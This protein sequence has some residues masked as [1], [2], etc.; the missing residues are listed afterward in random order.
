MK[1]FTRAYRYR[2]SLCLA[3]WLNDDKKYFHGFQIRTTHNSVDHF[4]W[5]RYF[6]FT[7]QILSPHVWH[8]TLTYHIRYNFILVWITQYG[9]GTLQYR[10]S[11]E[12]RCRKCAN[13]VL[14]FFMF[15]SRSVLFFY[16]GVFFYFFFRMSV[17]EQREHK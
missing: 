8:L 14:S 1:I 6:Y 15:L 4:F 13:R 9:T 12:W 3:E 10:Y 17:Y 16:N 11:S 5:I 7:N 2:Q